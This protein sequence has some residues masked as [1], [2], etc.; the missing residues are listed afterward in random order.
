[1]IKE[2]DIINYVHSK[3]FT[4]GMGI[5]Q[6]LSDSLALH[7]LAQGEYNRNYWFI[8]PVTGEKLV[9]RLNYGSQ[10]H[11]KN[12]IGYEFRAL[13]LLRESGRTPLPIFLDEDTKSFSDGILVESYI[14]GRSL[15][16]KKDLTQAMEC[17]AQIH[18]V[19]VPSGSG[20]IQPQNPAMAILSECKTMFSVYEA[21]ALKDAEIGARIQKMLERGA[22]IAACEIGQSDDRCLINTEL[23]STNFIV[24][25]Q[26]GKVS[27]VDWEKPIIGEPA[28]DLGHFLAPTTTFW[29]TDIILTE[30]EISDTLKQY[31]KAVHRRIDADHLYRKFGVYLPLNC[32]RGITWCAM[33]WVQY[34]LEQDGL[35]NE[36]TYHKLAQYL[37]DAFLSVIEDF[38]YDRC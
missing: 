9:L 34:H 5:P 32:L 1:M 35:R 10:M 12:Q 37:S 21:S 14:E 7:F 30:K 27:L 3:R 19:A 15:D 11:L 16:Y 8:H 18:S 17:L 23:N 28:Q 29:K 38:I 36:S 24:N 33:A 26:S 13:E 31:V 4:D 25:E 2:T 6:Q 20:M 22:Q